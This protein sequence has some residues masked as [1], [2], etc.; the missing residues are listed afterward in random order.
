MTAYLR[1]SGWTAI[2]D[3]AP[4]TYQL[5]EDSCSF[6]YVVV[7]AG[8]AGVAAARRLSELASDAQIALLDAELLL[9]N[10]SARNSGFMLDL[11][12]TKIDQRCSKVEKDWY[13]ELLK[14]G[15][16]LLW[17]QV[18]D[19]PQNNRYWSP[20]GHYK[21]ACTEAGSKVLESIAKVLTDEGLSYQ[22]VSSENC[23][24]NIGTSFYKKALWMPQ[25]TLVQPAELLYKLINT[26]PKNIQIFS[27]SKVIKRDKTSEGFILQVGQHRVDTKN[28]IWATNIFSK[29][30][31][32]GTKFMIPIY[33]YAG[34]T[35]P[36]GDSDVS[37]GT[38][39]EW[40][41]TPVEQLEATTRK[42]S[43]GR[44]LL[45]V[46]YSYK[47]ELPVFEQ[48]KIVFEGMK[49]RYANIQLDD[50]E[51]VWGGAVSMTRNGAP[52]F[53][54]LGA[55][56]MLVGGCNASG[57]LKMTALGNLSAE[58]LLN[59]DSDLLTET[60]LRSRPTYIPPEPF[61]SL[62]VS[63]MINRLKTRA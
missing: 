2:M 19:D 6:D 63:F 62:G 24:K 47:R 22:M 54:K 10:S 27:N 17:Q 36:L 9:E 21:A 43:N 23:Q 12:Y 25:C 39:D 41:V 49:K 46:G 14:Y 50:L 53:T 59:K 18:K 34:L 8:F 11:P 15:K 60:K 7:G 20:R 33:T 35:R 30:L 28:V 44:L 45:R 16:S 52:L 42:L 51:F 13:I 37:L 38:S 32:L 4:L 61:R 31:S 58:F 56:E 5:I 1:G 57:I 55:N 48:K 26:L 29:D 3:L 40:G